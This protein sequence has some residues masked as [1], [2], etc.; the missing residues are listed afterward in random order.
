MIF[1]RAGRRVSTAFF[2]HLGAAFQLNQHLP[3]LENVLEI[4]GGYGGLARIMKLM[5]PRTGFTLIDMPASLYYA[6][7]FLRAN[8]PNASFLYIDVVEK[9]GQLGD[10][11]DF[12]FLPSVWLDQVPRRSFDL[13][14]NTQSFS[15]MTQSAYDRFM[16]FIQA[17]IDVRYF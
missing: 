8:F 6:E 9:L 17:Q 13:V 2:W 5:S 16:H 7:V 11:W 14:I 3:A 1:E 15:E 4:G 10:K 12:V